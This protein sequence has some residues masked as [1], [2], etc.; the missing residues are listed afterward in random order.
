MEMVLLTDIC[1]D[2][3]DFLNAYQ[4][5]ADLSERQRGHLRH[6]RHCKVVFE[7]TLRLKH[8][9]KRAVER[10]AVPE[11]LT[12]KILRSIRND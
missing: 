4:C 2:N 11:D 7:E 1:E 10:T 6:C 5:E 9:L 3:A 12:S 8:I